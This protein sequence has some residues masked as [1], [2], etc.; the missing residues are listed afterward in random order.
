V[1]EVLRAPSFAPTPVRLPGPGE[2]DPDLSHAF[3]SSWREG[4]DAGWR[5][6]FA[7]GRAE[8]S[9]VAANLAATVESMAD[10]YRRTC[11]QAKAALAGS[12]VDLAEEL[13]TGVLG[14]RPD[15][16]TAGLVERLGNALALIDDGPLTIV[17]HPSTLEVIVPVLDASVATMPIEARADARLRPG[18]ARIEGPWASAELTWPKLVAAA[19]EALAELAVDQ[20][21]ADAT[22]AAA[23]AAHAS[24]PTDDEVA[25]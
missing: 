11:A 21:D 10:A 16:A 25:V 20:A 15:A 18:E 24:L 1:A 23:V 6:G 4:H 2:R 3:E 9:G 22:R 19:R 8:L 14:H 5:D 17:V 7:A 13:V 12:L